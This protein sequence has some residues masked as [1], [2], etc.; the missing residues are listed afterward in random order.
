MARFTATTQA[1]RPH[2][3][4]TSP[5]ENHYPSAFALFEADK[6]SRSRVSTFTASSTSALLIDVK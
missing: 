5:A 3:R 6:E 1:N 2:S 4:P